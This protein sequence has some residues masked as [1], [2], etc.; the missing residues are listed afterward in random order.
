V[1]RRLFAS[2]RGNLHRASWNPIRLNHHGTVEIRSMDA[3]FPEV[4][5]AVCALIC[6]AVDRLR[7]ER[8]TVRPTRQV[9]TIELD[10]DD[11]LV[12]TFSY[13]SGELLEAAVTYGVLD[14]R[15]EAYLDSFV[16]FACAYVEEPALVESLEG[17]GSGYRTTEAELLHSFPL[18]EAT[19]SRDQGL[20]LVQ[21]SCRRLGDEVASLQR[22]HH[23]ARHE[24][25]RGE[26][27]RGLSIPLEA[28]RTPLAM[29]RVDGKGGHR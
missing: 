11:L 26:I 15:I 21:R 29:N 27:T 2:T 14:Q 1:D 7:H 23:R 12:P 17:P 5:L 28:A 18:R 25:D 6:G 10:G 4:I 24:G 19:V 16:G 22:K 8:L 20:S 13:L 9:R 3:N